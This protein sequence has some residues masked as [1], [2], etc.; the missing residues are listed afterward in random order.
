VLADI[1]LRRVT[2]LGRNVEKVYSVPPAAYTAARRRPSV[3]APSIAIGRSPT[4]LGSA[5]AMS[6]PFLEAD[7]LEPRL[8]AQAPL[9]PLTP[10]TGMRRRVTP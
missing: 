2:L 1:R 10:Y 4:S 5:Y 9:N 3:P 7:L 8:A 6:F